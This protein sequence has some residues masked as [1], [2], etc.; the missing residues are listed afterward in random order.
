LFKNDTFPQNQNDGIILVDHVMEPSSPDS[1]FH[2]HLPGDSTHYYYAAY[3]YDFAGNFSEP[4]L[5][6]G[7]SAE[8]TVPPGEVTIVSFDF[9]SDTVVV[10]FTTPEDADFEGVR[11][12]YDFTDFPQHIYDGTL[13]LDNNY[14]NNVS[15]AETLGGVTLDTTYYFTFFCR[16]SIPNFSSGIRDSLYTSEDTIP[17]DTI[18]SFNSTQIIPDTIVL[19]WINPDDFETIKIRYDTIYY[20]SHHDSGKGLSVPSSS[21]GDTVL[22][23]WKNENFAPGV[24]YYFSGFTID[25][26]G[27]VSEPAHTFC[28]TPKLT[29][30]DE[31]YPVEPSEGGYGSWHDSVEVSFTAPLQISSLQTGVSIQGREVYG[32][33]IE[34]DMNNRYIFIPP[35][36]SALDTVHVTLNPTI[37]DSVGNPFDGNGNGIPDSTDKYIWYF[38][39]DKFIYIIRFQDKVV[40]A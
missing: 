23:V 25:K 22:R 3:A 38:T 2:L 17:P 32:F 33:H 39:T 10:H 29:Q 26:T 19:S 15:V 6:H 34:K 8:D 11:I 24:H 20:P 27:N 4:A 30:V 21:P 31:T 7:I 1:F 14:N 35:A 13:F 5:I 37:K 18:M 28:L 9:W 36:F 12:L 16:D 40:I